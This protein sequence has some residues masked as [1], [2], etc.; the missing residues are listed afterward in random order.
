MTEP[1]VMLLGFTVPDELAKQLFSLDVGPAVQTHKFAWSLTRALQSGFGRVVLASACPIQNYPLGRKILFRGGQFEAQNVKG[2]L[3]GFINLLVLKHLTRFLAC[4]LVL[5]RLMRQYQV[6]WLFVHGTHTPFLLFGLLAKLFG[7]K[8][9]VVLTDPPGVLLPTDS[10]AARILKRMDVV[11]VS[12]ALAHADAVISLAPELIQRFAIKKPYLVFPGI[13]DSSLVQ[14]INK[15]KASKL[16]RKPFVILYAG[17]LNQAYGVDR[18]IDAVENMTDSQAVQLKLF[19][20]G[21][22]EQ[23]IQRLAA[24]DS[25]FYY[26]G[27][28]GNEQLIPELLQADLLVNPRPTHES[29]AIMSFPSK[30]IEYLATGRPV[31]TTRIASIPDAYHPYFFYIEDESSNGVK[32]AIVTLMRM[33]STKREAYALQGQTFINKEATEYAT[34]CKIADLIRLIE[35]TR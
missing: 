31:L 34:G 16:T 30:L 27:F 29:F 12:S 15:E 23:K 28:V 13:L 25:R 20:R 5:P 9:V 14:M 8:L 11:L 24:S 32:N 10:R 7:K 18:L 1:N 4:L 2:V 3:L 35:I 19:G 17:G 22:Q 6:D 26:G 33:D 21:D